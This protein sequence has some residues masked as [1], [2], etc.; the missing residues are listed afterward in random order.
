MSLKSKKITLPLLLVLLS[1]LCV[2]ALSQAEDYETG[3]ISAKRAAEQREAL[4]KKTEKIR[5]KKEAAAKKKA[6]EAAGAAA[7]PTAPA[8][9]AQPEAPKE[10]AP[11]K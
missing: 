6:E 4:A 11:A 5:L 10:T 9:P 1:A 2:P 7:Q 8:E 3:P